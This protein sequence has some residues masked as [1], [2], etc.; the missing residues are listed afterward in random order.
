MSLSQALKETVHDSKN[1]DLLANLPQTLIIQMG[2]RKELTPEEVTL[3]IGKKESEIPKILLIDE[4]DVFFSKE[5]YN[6]LYVPMS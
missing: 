5:F 1:L 3:I 4:V 6:K 2:Q